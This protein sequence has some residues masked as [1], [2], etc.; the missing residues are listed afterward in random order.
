LRYTELNP[1]RAGMVAAAQEWIWSSA[2]VHCGVTVHD[3]WLAMELWNGRWDAT[4]WTGFLAAGQS[5]S[6]KKAMRDCT[7]TGRPL[8]TDEFIHELEVA[9]KRPLAP[10]KGGRPAKLAAEMRQGELYFGQ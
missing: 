2:A 6:E 8:G 10:R 9:A 1:V 4:S 5:E 3:P 7:H